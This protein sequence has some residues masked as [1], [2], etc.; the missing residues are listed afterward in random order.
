MFHILNILL[1]ITSNA[2]WMANFSTYL[3]HF[4]RPTC[5]LQEVN[6]IHFPIPMLLTLIFAVRLYVV[7]VAVGSCWS[8][9]ERWSL[10]SLLDSPI[11]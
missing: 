6:I 1:A 10:G 4:I 2:N 3:L 7:P 8:L 5:H 11:N 9:S